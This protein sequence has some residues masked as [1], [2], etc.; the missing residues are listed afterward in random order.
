MSKESLDSK[1]HFKQIFTGRGG[2]KSQKSSL[3]ISIIE[4]IFE[5]YY[6]YKKTYMV[7]KYLFLSI[8]ALILTVFQLYVFSYK[9][10]SFLGILRTF[11]RQVEFSDFFTLKYTL[12]LLYQTVNLHS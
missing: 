4:P 12:T 5:I 6:A 9:I 7:I 11:R 2:V 8:C 1:K 10:T 3:K